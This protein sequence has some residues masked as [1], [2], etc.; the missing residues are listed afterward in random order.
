M[1]PSTVGTALCC[2]VRMKLNKPTDYLE[3][4]AEQFQLILSEVENVA[5]DP[6]ELVIDISNKRVFGLSEFDCMK[7][8]YYGVKEIIRRNRNEVQPDTAA[9]DEIKES[10]DEPQ[11]EISLTSVHS[12]GTYTKEQ[13]ECDAVAEP[14]EPA[15]ED[16]AAPSEEVETPESK[17]S[18]IPDIVESSDKN[19]EAN[20]PTVEVGTTESN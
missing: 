17:E 12:N 9:G 6:N 20:E 1:C 4:I 15:M 14:E 2:C 13:V 18:A 5:C 10:V 8:V 16:V 7:T 3:E 19:I 11:T